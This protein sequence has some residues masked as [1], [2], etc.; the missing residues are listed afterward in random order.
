ME[1]GVPA[2]VVHTLLGEDADRRDLH[3]SEHAF[4]E[5]GHG[6]PTC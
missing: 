5:L 6:L 4:Q 3:V 1:Q 2:G